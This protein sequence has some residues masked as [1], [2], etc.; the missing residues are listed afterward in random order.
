VA[1]PLSLEARRALLWVALQ[2]GGPGS[3]DRLVADPGMSPGDA[4]RAASGLTSEELAARWRA[5]LMAAKPTVYSGLG[6]TGGL[7]V[8]WFLV[9][10]ALALR[11]T[12][13]RSA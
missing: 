3:F 4:L 2:E 13:W 5:R 6:A 8:F 11:S 7:A 9:F 12:R 10:G 1:A